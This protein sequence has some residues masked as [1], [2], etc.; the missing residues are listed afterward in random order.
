[1][2]SSP[3][4]IAPEPVYDDVTWVSSYDVNPFEVPIAEK[5]ALLIDWTERLRAGRGGRPRDGRGRAGAGEQVLRRPGRHGD[6]PAAG[7]GRPRASRRWAPAPTPS[8][9]WRASPPPV[10]RGWEYLTDRPLRLGRRA[11]RGARAAR[12]EAQGADHRGRPL[13][14]GHPPVQPLADHPRVDRPR[15]R[16]RPRARLRGQLRRHV[17]RDLRQAQHAAVRLQH[18]ERHRRPHR[19][20][21]PG[22]DRVRRRGRADP[23]LGHRPRRR[24]GRLPARPPDGRT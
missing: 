2:T 15:H 20:A 10:G 11:R 24:P 14:P 23:E 4:E 3:V 22:H 12:R 9:R 18:H 1:M 16:A 7:P 21:R 17:V 19:R 8:T 6:H 5:A 13:R